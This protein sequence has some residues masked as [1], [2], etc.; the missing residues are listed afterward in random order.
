M[1]VKQESIKLAIQNIV[2][3]SAS[4]ANGY[5]GHYVPSLV[6]VV[7]EAVLED[8]LESNINKS[9]AEQRGGKPANAISNLVNYHP[10]RAGVAGAN[11]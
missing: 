11:V 8:V 2:F 9:D 10:G 6:V 4:G 3:C 1:L 7:Q 5:L